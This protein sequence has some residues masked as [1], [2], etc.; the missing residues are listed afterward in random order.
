MKNTETI[1][2]PTHC[3]ACATTLV[4]IN[5]QLFCR[6]QGCPAQSNKKIESFCKTLKIKGLGPK[7]IEKL[8]IEDIPDIYNLELDYLITM[9][10]EKTA[11][12]INSLIQDTVSGVDFGTFLSALSIPLIGAT[13]SRKIGTVANSLSD[14]T[15]PKLKEAGIGEKARSN[16]LNWL[17]NNIQD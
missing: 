10:G 14:I 6:N 4:E 9:L 7:T 12:K 2:I 11:I 8:E 17:K 15:D 3:P 16:L 13:A 5:F 1:Q